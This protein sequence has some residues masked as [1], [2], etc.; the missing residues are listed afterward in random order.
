MGATGPTYEQRPLPGHRV[1]ASGAERHTSQRWGAVPPLA[2]REQDSDLRPPGYE[3]GELP[4]CSIPLCVV[5]PGWT[6]G[7]FGDLRPPFI[8]LSP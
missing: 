2:W 3:P 5:V 8:H 6:E 7:G 4:D 1:T